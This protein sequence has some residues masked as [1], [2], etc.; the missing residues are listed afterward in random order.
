VS[1]DRRIIEDLIPVQ[2]INEV[3]QREKI[4][5][6]ATHPRKLH[7]WWARR[8]LAAAR[9][10]V[11]AT[12]VR[13]ED[14]PEEARSPAFF[15]EL[16]RWGASE[17]TIAD[18]RRRVLEANGGTPPRVL[19]LFAGGG[20]I[21]LE[22]ARLGCEA[23]AV[24][25]N[26]V[27]HMIELCMLDYP[28]RFGPRLADDIRKWGA[29]WVDRTWERVGHLY[30]RAREEEGVRQLDFASEQHEHER[31]SGRP[32]AYLWTRT[33]RCPNPALAEH[34][35]P[36]V[37]Q[38]W[39]AKRRGRMI[40]LRPH[41][42]REALCLDWD[43]V[44]AGDADGLGFDPAAFSTRGRSTCLICG[45]AIEL[46]YVKAEG[47]AGRMGIT[48]LAAVLVKPSGAG[49]DYVAVGDYPQPS[50]HES[51]AVLAALDVKPPEESVC[52]YMDAGFRVAPYGLTRFRD[53]F[54]PRQLATLCAFAQ[55]VRETYSEMRDSG[56]EENRAEAVSAFLGLI[57]SRMSDYGSTLCRWDGR[58]Q[59]VM[60]TY[61]RQVLP[62]VWDFVESN[63]FANAAGDAATY[64]K[65]IAAIV[66]DLAVVGPRVEVQ[67]T[68]A[69]QLP[70]HDGT[71]DAVI[72]D[73]P[74][75][76]NISYADLSD[77]F[78]V[79]LKR[80]IGFLFP[81]H[82]DGELTPKRRE[83]TSFG[84]RHGGT[85]RDGRR[86]YEREMGAAFREAH[87]VLKP[88]APL[89]CVYA[90]KTT[91]GWAALVEALRQA[92]FGVTEA[93]PLD[94]EMPERSRGQNS[95]ALASSIFLVARRR[96]RDEVGQYG[97]VLRELDEVVRERLERLTAAGVSGSDLVIATIGAGLRPFT[98]YAKVELPNGE[99]I[100]A[101]RFLEEVQARVLSAVLAEV[102]GLENGVGAIDAATRYY[103]IARYSFGYV[104]VEF[105]EANNLARTAG[106]ELSDLASGP[107]PL[108]SITRGNVH[109][110]DF[111]TRGQEPSLGVESSEAGERRVIDVL[112][113]LLWRAAHDTKGLRPYLDEA[114]PD[115]EKLRRVAQ[116]LQ[117][118][119]LAVENDQKPAEARA[120]E[121][122]L[123]GWRT[124]VDDNLLTS[125]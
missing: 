12:L 100:P 8:P 39:L 26:P 19:D 62:M 58:N 5:H 50:V 103:V 31:A 65:T 59:T 60:N 67:R 101:E 80:S 96:E 52:A 118:K 97:S 95:A 110:L 98:R 33:V 14:T 6:A 90:H 37:R 76:D 15:R 49:R 30:P 9:A 105:D 72:T 18:A 23:T 4:G 28:A 68:S 1:D 22:A 117:G 20:A 53:L 106:V 40:A 70:D 82:L 81:E 10:A 119:G 69:S 29:R 25:L 38:T 113:G 42:D 120:C 27:A 71:F 94:T 44:E 36:L 99:A 89:V 66:E 122:L 24:E 92:R 45:A 114:R 93:W 78:Y 83:I 56:M 13:T 102:H 21:P 108:A 124:L 61:A 55:G 3:A 77:F 63:P 125:R 123:G 47:L 115:T 109:M 2:A 48:A 16:C 54:T 46:D 107:T 74:Y 116:A 87:R 32:I 51:E 86:F 43:V 57:A 41:I 84:E 85:A 91:L 112:H 35:V 11:Y 104:D 121:R 17:D 34:E 88:N 73:P 79:W 75:Y 64:V 111:E 7:L